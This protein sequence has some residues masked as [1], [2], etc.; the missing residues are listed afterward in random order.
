MF[1]QIYKISQK[2]SEP[3]G[4]FFRNTYKIQNYA[5]TKQIKCTLKTSKVGTIFSGKVILDT[6]C[7]KQTN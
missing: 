5:I 2:I 3:L 1:V 6:I 4:I 7:P